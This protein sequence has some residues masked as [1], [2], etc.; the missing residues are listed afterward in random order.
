MNPAKLIGERAEMPIFTT[1]YDKALNGLAI[2]L[3]K[4]VKTNIEVRRLI[5]DEVLLQFDG[6]YNTLFTT[7]SSMNVTSY[8]PA[9]ATRTGSNNISMGDLLDL[10]FPDGDIK[11]RSGSES[12]MKYLQEL[13]PLFQIAVPVGAEGWNPSEYT[14][15]IVFVTEDYEDGVTTRVPG[16]NADGDFV[17]VD[18][19]NEPDRPVIVINTNERIDESG[20]ILTRLLA[21]MDMEMNDGIDDGGGVY[22]PPPPSTPGGI[23]ALAQNG[24]ITISWNYVS[25]ATSYIVYR[26]GPND[27]NFRQLAT[28]VGA[29]NTVH[30]DKLFTTDSVNEYHYY[31]VVAYN[32]N[33]FLAS[34]PTMTVQAQAPTVPSIPGNF[35]VQM[36]F[37]HGTI[38]VM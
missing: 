5:S 34:Y 33:Y 25:G 36:S 27:S 31:Y 23:T 38:M 7:V 24:G 12:V 22:N 18:A 20:D 16:Y 11:T 14:P 17:W 29:Y 2:A 21:P 35:K 19:I 3:H 4:A 8:D 15:T 13:Y 37:Y 9:V 1:D 32:D 10:Y 28:L 30:V 6:D 26:K